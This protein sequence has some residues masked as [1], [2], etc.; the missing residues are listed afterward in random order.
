MVFLLPCHGL[1][2]SI[3]PGGVA[4]IEDGLFSSHSKAGYVTV[5][6]AWDIFRPYV[7]LAVAVFKKPNHIVKTYL[8]MLGELAFF[9]FADLSP[10]FAS[11]IT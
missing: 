9:K 7:A 6:T 11:C 10:W 3:Y 5:D 2:C 1:V 8:M 4:N